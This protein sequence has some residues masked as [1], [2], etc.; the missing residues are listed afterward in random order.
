MKK[1]AKV[2]WVTASG[3]KGSGVIVT[4]EDDLGTVLVAVDAP[5]GEPHYVIHCTVTWLTVVP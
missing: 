3:V 5:Q 4:D 2:T 1:G